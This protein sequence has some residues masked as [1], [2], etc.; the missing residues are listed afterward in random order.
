MVKGLSPGMIMNIL[1]GLFNSNRDTEASAPTDTPST[2]SQNGQW[3]SIQP[4]GNP[5]GTGPVAPPDANSSRY[6]STNEDR[7]VQ[8]KTRDTRRTAGLTKGKRRTPPS[9]WVNPLAPRSSH[10]PGM[11]Q[12]PT[13]GRQPANPFGPRRQPQLGTVQTP[14]FGQPS[15]RIP[16]QGVSNQGLNPFGQPWG[17]VPGGFGQPGV[18]RQMPIFNEWG[19]P[20][21]RRTA[22]PPG[23]FGFPSQSRMMGYPLQQ[24]MSNGS[25]YPGMPRRPIRQFQEPWF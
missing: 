8:E 24:R 13:G 6:D 10:P 21:Q 4:W 18:R 9:A 17:G 7:P 3:Q 19:V 23:T 25:V 14:R 11:N 16:Q 12:R 22:V 20:L 15:M 5:E 1:K 2:E